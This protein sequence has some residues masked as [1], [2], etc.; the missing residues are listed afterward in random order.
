VKPSPARSDSASSAA[1]FTPE[2]R[3]RLI[4][5][6]KLEAADLIRRGE[7]LLGL[8]LRATRNDPEGWQATEEL[9]KETE[10]SR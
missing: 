9:E 10:A 2:F 7:Y 4:A 3:S 1:P 5:A 8:A 6:A